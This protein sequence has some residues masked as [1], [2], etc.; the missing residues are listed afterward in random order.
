MAPKIIKPF[1]LLTSDNQDNPVLVR[2]PNSVVGLPSIV[3]STP[4]TDPSGNLIYTLSTSVAKTL[5]VTPTN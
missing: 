5:F 1:G 4:C 3:T 2:K